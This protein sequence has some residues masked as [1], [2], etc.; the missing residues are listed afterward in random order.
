MNKEAD[1]VRI[2]EFFDLMENEKYDLRKYS[3]PILVY[4]VEDGTVYY[5]LW[6]EDI[7]DRFGL[8]NV[9]GWDYKDDAG[10]CP[11]W[12]IGLDYNELLEELDSLDDD[13]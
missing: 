1:R 8:K 6:E 3:K 4:K 5:S 9:D 13:L 12:V 2:R 7:L 10:F 11:D